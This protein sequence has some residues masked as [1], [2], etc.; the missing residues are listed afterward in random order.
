ML[1]IKKFVNFT[2]IF[3]KTTKLRD[4]KYFYFNE[5]KIYIFSSESSQLL[6]QTGWILL[7]EEN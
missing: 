5:L 1:R 3:V 6:L 4:E 7:R 2:E